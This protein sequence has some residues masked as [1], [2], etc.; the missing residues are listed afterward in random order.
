MPDVHKIDC[1]N[2]SIGPLKKSIEGM[3]EALKDGLIMTL[4]SSIKKDKGNVDEF[5]QKGMSV[6]TAKP[7]SVEEISKAKSEAVRIAGEKDDI[8]DV[9]KECII[10]NKMLRQ[11]AGQNVEISDVESRWAN[12]EMTLSAFNELIEEQKNVVKTEIDSRI[13]K[14]NQDIEKFYARWSALK[15]KERDQ[16]DRNSAKEI[17]LKMKEWREDWSVLEKRI[18]DSIRDSEHFS[19]PVPRFSYYQE[20]QTELV[21]QEEDWKFYET[22][23][24]ELEEMEKE[25]W[26]SFRSKIYIFQDFLGAWAERIKSRE[27]SIVTN[28]LRGSVEKYKKGY[29]IYKQIVG[30]AFEKEHWLILFRLLHINKSTTIESLLFRELVE[31]I[32]YLLENASDVKELCARAQGEVTLREAINEL[33]VWCE[34]VE[35]QLTEHVQGDKTTPLIKEWKEIM[36]QVSDHQSL[37]INLKE[38]RYFSRFVDQVEQFE[39]K[40]GGLDDYLQKLNIIQRKWVYLEPIFG[41]GALPQEQGR[42]R[43]VD[44]EYRSIM[45]GI[46]SNPKVLNLCTIPG[47]KD[48]LDM[49]L[50]QLERCQKA[51]NDYLEEKR[52]KFSRFYFIGDDDL[53]E[54]LGQ[55]KNVEVIQTHLKKLFA[56]IHLVEFNADSTGIIA[57]KSSAKEYVPLPESVRIENEVELWLGDLANQM[58]A[59]LQDKL[60]KCLKD[61][62]L[63]IVNQPSQI[64]CLAEQIHFTE[65]TYKCIKENQL[66]AF[67]AELDKKLELYTTYDYGENQLLLLK[68]KALI[69]D[70]IHHIDIIDTLVAKNVSTWQDWEWHRQLKFRLNPQDDMCNIFMCSAVFKYSYEYQGNAP[71]LV[72]SPLIDKCYL[73]LTQGMKLGYGGN[74]Y[75]PAGTGKTESVKALGRAFGRQVLVFNC[76]EGIDFQS[77]GRIF[78]GLIKC[79]AWGCF[80]EFNRLLEEQLSAI[81]QQIQVIQWAIKEK[82][83]TVVLL[84]RTIEVNANAG[85]FVTMNP[86][87]KGY[88]GRQKLPDNLKQLFRPV[89]MSAPDYELIAEVLLF[90]EG[91]KC[92]KQLALKICSLFDLCKQLLSYQQ[93]YD[94][95]L[96][97]LKTVLIIGGTLIEKEK[98]AGKK[99][100]FK[101]E[102]VLLIKA[103][104]VNTLSK[105]T[106]SDSNKFQ[107]IL[108][109]CF[110]GITIQDIGY[111]ELEKAIT[112]AIGELKLE[113]IEK[114][115]RKMMQFHENLNQRMGV[116]LVGPSGCGKSTIWNVLKSAY[117]KLKQPLCTYVMNPKSMPRQQLLGHMDSDTREWTDGV[118]TASAREVVKEVG[119]TKSWIVCDGDIDPEWVESL[120]TVLDDSHLLTLPSGER[121]NFGSNVNF[122]F[123]TNNL[124]FA[125]PATVSRMGVLYLSEEDVDVKR[126]VNT[127][128]RKQDIAKVPKLG[129]WIED[130]F[131]KG[132]SWILKREESLVVQT[133]KVGIVSNVLSHLDG[134]QTKG[135]FAIGLIR[136]FGSNLKLPLRTKFATE[137]FALM[138]EKPTDPSKPLDCTYDPR[139]DS[140]KSY[141][142]LPTTNPQEGEILDHDRPPLIKTISAQR[143]MDLVFKWIENMEP[144][145]IVGPE[146]CGKNLLLTYLFGQLKATQVATIHCNAQTGAIHVI[147]K[148]NQICAQSS[149]SQGRVYRPRECSRL[150]LYLKDI[151]LPHPD[152]YDTIQLIAFLQ[153]LVTY[154]GFYDENLEFVHLERIQIIAS[155]NPSTTVGR[156]VLNSR[157]TANVRLA[158]YDYPSDTELKLIFQQFVEWTLKRMP[159]L[160][161]G[162]LGNAPK[163]I[164][165]FVVDTYK[166]V[167]KKF[168]IDEFRHYLFTPRDL[169]QWIFGLLRYDVPNEDDLKD[170]LL[171]EGKRIFRDKLVGKET[172]LRFDNLL[173]S[174]AKKY[175]V[176][177]EISKEETSFYLTSKDKSNIRNSIPGL[178]RIPYQDFK[179]FTQ[180]L[181]T[182]YEREEKEIGLYL[183]EEVLETISQEDRVLSRP[184]GAI[185]LAGVSGVGRRTLTQVVAYLRGLDFYSPKITRDYSLKEFKR[186]LKALISDLVIENKQALLFLEDHQLV[187]ESFL[188]YINSLICSSEIPG[189]YTPEELEPIL[190]SLQD[191]MKSQYEH[192]HIFDY[193]RSKIKKNLRIVLSLDNTHHKFLS[194]CSSNPALYAKYILIYI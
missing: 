167:R 85:I 140:F 68:L 94:W 139:S 88:G 32:D 40:L 27:R 15:P 130:Y 7:Q 47:L 21:Q 168:S 70:L 97:A 33:R 9:Y 98:K 190:A 74:P 28:Y 165:E 61:E 107:G 172:R 30:D 106:Y 65:S 157:F 49:I 182:S 186:D 138:G 99:L 60:R 52:S 41:R 187:E 55:G 185:L 169:T 161:S 24:T 76:D 3:L 194:H 111:E 137:F 64:V 177:K 50:D 117:E 158:Y 131:Y 84:E 4:K 135:S 143:D 87:G 125:S 29:P 63:D 35:F 83:P 124:R 156:H 112:E 159:G 42:F 136:G 77:M 78:I 163:K 192:R 91:F 147:Q 105:L 146:G 66:R 72:H 180:Q 26:L 116:V 183:F 12:L 123:E 11:L 176:F 150:I 69:L 109:D 184:G 20:I 13:I 153:Q 110:P 179:T 22:F 170:I 46:G 181:M 90:S 39:S 108:Q 38:S 79:G 128:L 118:L 188:Q 178:E 193:F 126:L 103:I 54:I 34:T 43:R 113:L 80:D 164:G 31:S 75:G 56:G 16:I 127:W 44:D 2:I 81:S 145:I 115:V 53:L 141:F 48:S 25:D 122:I 17:A 144:V 155:M 101:E 10:K 95:N 160:G 82:E 45:L 121:I 162:N 14:L 89:A 132:L 104:R 148:L 134:A 154:H 142:F 73:T 37:L 86:A 174:W 133:T 67:K 5:L 151:N 59:T 119:N 166:D 6:L 18:T 173:Y 51:L 100:K 152:K 23:S 114:Q 149:V 62:Q 19:M 102:A 58:K 36:T 129:T 189:L 191:E 93:H 96:R 1:F 57:M 120:N 171:Y 92:A 8:K 71:K 175:Q